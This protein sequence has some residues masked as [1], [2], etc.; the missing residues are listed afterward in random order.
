MQAVRLGLTGFVGLLLMAAVSGCV[1]EGAPAVAAP[2]AQPA[3]FDETTG[4][5][6]GLVHD[7][8]FLPVSNAIVALGDLPEIQGTTD[9]GGR[10]SFS[11]VPAGEH[12]LFVSAL[13]YE[14]AGKS[15]EVAAG[16]VTQMDFI[17]VVIPIETPFY[18]IKTLS[19]LFGCGTSWR[20]AVVY[21]GIAICGAL[22][23]VGDPTNAD[24]FL[25]VWQTTGPVEAWS[26]AVFETVWTSNQAFGSG[27]SVNWEKNGCANV[28]D[29]RFVRTAGHSPLRARLAGEEFAEKMDNVTDNSCSDECTFDDCRLMTRVFSMPDTLGAS[30][31][32]DVGFTFQQVFHQY[33][34]EFYYDDG[35]ETFS[36]VVDG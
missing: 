33:L 15:I 20:P 34:T 35:P 11:H 21:S 25:L 14:S 12:T 24:N 36:A 13:G 31:P 7:D 29:A 10:F 4:G 8:N 30:S 17:L 3:E 19:G 9:E 6:E 23:I 28:A 27:L 22:D 32:A 16:I 2:E 18:E 1:A 5:I 26:A